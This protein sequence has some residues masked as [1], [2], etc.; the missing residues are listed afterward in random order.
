M[1]YAFSTDTPVTVA[2]GGSWGTALAHLLATHGMPV[3]LWLR[4][5]SI[6][7]AINHER[8]NPRYLPQLSLHPALQATTDPAVLERELLVLAVPCQQLRHWLTTY[9]KYFRSNVVLVNAAK[10]L[11][12][13]SHARCSIIAAETLQEIEPKYAVLSGPSFA[14]E[15]IQGLPSAVVLATE[16][17]ALG[18]SLQHIFSGPAFRCYSS[19]DVIGVEIGGAL[20]NVMAIAAGLCDGLKLGHNSRAALIT[21]GLAEMCRLGVA[22]GARQ[23]TFMGLSGLGDLTLTCTGDMSRNRQVGLGLAQGKDLADITAALGMVS[24]GVKTTSAVH[25]LASLLGIEAPITTAVMRILNGEQH[26]HDALKQLMIRNLRQ[27]AS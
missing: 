19:T 5:A 16:D 4:D 14:A 10:G 1:S 26:P 25:E 2:G 20:K 13:G 7:R 8:S 18:H 12:I 11:E 24:E 17:A 21:R 23:E 27:E 9:R 15:V 3:T 22:C 6:A